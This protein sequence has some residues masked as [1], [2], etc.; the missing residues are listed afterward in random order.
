MSGQ[1]PPFAASRYANQVLALHEALAL[2]RM[3]A[4]NPTGFPEGPER[5][6]AVLERATEPLRVRRAKKVPDA[7]TNESSKD[8][9]RRLERRMRV[10]MTPEMALIHLNSGSRIGPDGEDLDA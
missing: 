1:L 5:A 10:G 6:A 7:V 2:L 3:Y 4:V 9:A 8:R